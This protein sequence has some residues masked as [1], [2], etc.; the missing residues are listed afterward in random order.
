MLVYYSYK[1]IDAKTGRAIYGKIEA[2][3]EIALEQMLA[4]S[5]MTLVSAKEIKQSKLASF[6]SFAGSIKHKDLITMFITL[7]QLQRAGVPLLDSLKDLKDFTENPKLK[8]TMQSIYES[9]KGGDMLSTAMSKH[10]KIFSEIMISLV[11]MGEKTG[12]LDKAFKNIYEN[13]KWNMEI[14]KKIKKAVTGPSLSI[15]MLFGIATMMLK[16]VVPKVLG[17]ILDQGIK[18]PSYTEALI[19]TSN[20]IFFCF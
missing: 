11:A 16:V 4:E 8:Q 12:E 17:F 5:D 15:A 18:V 20:F 14:N 6:L 13:I 19:A 1:A 10:P 9:V 7:E 2:P 3:N